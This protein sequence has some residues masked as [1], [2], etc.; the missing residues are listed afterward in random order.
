[1][2]LDEH[3]QRGL[4]LLTEDARQ[5]PTALARRLGVPRSTV[6]ERITRLERSGVIGG[7]TVKPGPAASDGTRAVTAH[8][9]IVVDP[10]ASSSVVGALSRLSEVRTVHTVS[11]PFDLL[12][13]VSAA[14]PAAIDEVLDRIGAVPGVERT[15]S[16]ILLTTRIDR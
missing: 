1:M 2:A 13:V 3:D 6:Q 15:T 8:V 5:G 11:G 7:Y 14:S 12:A 4:R 16:S 10:K 9:S